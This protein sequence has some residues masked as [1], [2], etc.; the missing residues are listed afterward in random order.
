MDGMS[1][2]LSTTKYVVAVRFYCYS[3]IVVIWPTP[4]L[5]LITVPRFF[6]FFLTII[7]SSIVL[8]YIFCLC[9]YLSYELERMDVSVVR[10]KPSCIEE[11]AEHPSKLL[12][13][14]VS[15]VT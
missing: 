6:L 8:Y 7:I 12:V 1:G 11:D 10:I 5:V 3:Y 15:F 14:A 9:I 13:A 2:Y 4:R